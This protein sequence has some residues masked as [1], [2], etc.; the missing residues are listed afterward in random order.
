MQ[1]YFQIYQQNIWQISTR[2]RHLI[3]HLNSWTP[4][5]CGSNFKST[6]FKLIIQNSS[7]GTHCEIALMLM[8]QN[9]TDETLTL[10]QL[11]AWSRQARNHY[12]SQCSPRSVSPY[13]I[14]KPQWVNSSPPSA[15]YMIQWIE[16][17]LI[18]IMAC[19][20]FRTKPLSEPMQGYCQLIGMKFYEILIKIQTFSFTKMHL[21]LSS[22][23]WRPFC[24]QEMS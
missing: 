17:A 24:P 4:G 5:W 9:L 3:S 18:Q 12:L 6:I 1:N 7:L 8:P 10:V 2:K 16:S 11:I 14:T 22:A 21:K 15:A 19:R 13:G 20:L 23:E